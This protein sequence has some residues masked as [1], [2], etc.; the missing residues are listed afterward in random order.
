MPLYYLIM[1]FSFVIG[2]F[3]TADFFLIGFNLVRSLIKEIIGLLK[4]M[5]G[6]MITLFR[7][8]L[9]LGSILTALG[10]ITSISGLSKIRLFSYR[11]VRL[12]YI[13]AYLFSF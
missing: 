11:L 4:L 1:S 10:S 13:K 8:W 3:S 12:L 9:H 7:S 5:S 2:T 6:E